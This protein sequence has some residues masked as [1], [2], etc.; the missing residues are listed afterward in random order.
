MTSAHQI[1]YQRRY[2][3][4]LADA[5]DTYLTILQIVDKRVA[6]ALGRDAPHWRVLNACPACNY[7]VWWAS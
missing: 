2:R 6:E 7:E 5:F 3:N 1:P 4:A